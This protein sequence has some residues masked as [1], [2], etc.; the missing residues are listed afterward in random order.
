LNALRPEDFPGDSVDEWSEFNHMVAVG[1]R[2][3]AGTIWE[4]AASL[5][6][7]RE[8]MN[9]AK[10]GTKRALE[11]WLPNWPELTGI[12]R[13]RDALTES[14]RRDSSNADSHSA[15]RVASDV[16]EVV[17]QL[18]LRLASHDLAV[19][20]S[21]FDDELEFALR[22]TQADKVASGEILLPLIPTDFT[23]SDETRVIRPLSTS[24]QLRFHGQELKNCLGGGGAQYIRRG[25]KGT[26]FIVGV[27]EKG[28]GQAFSTAEISVKRNKGLPRYSF[29]VRQHTAKKNVRPTPQCARAVAE[30]LR[31]CCTDE[32]RK[33]LED[34]WRKIQERYRVHRGAWKLELEALVTE[35]L[36]RTITD[37]VYDEALT[38]IQEALG[39][40]ASEQDFGPNQP[41]WRG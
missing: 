15:N 23:S 37:A 5:E 38:S 29:V 27:F 30:L 16:P 31:Y 35:A 21:Q 19:I 25:S 17:N 7:L 18:L 41:Q 20:A 1:Q 11:L 39:E 24:L 6:W 28:S 32:V 3:F 14:L 36:R 9:R 8:C 13:F 2:L 22:E 40:S 33:Y 12:V 34:N 26:N 10:R 4:S